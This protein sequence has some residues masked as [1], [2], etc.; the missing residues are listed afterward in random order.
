VIVALYFIAVLLC[1]R[2]A[3]ALSPRKNNARPKGTRAKITAERWLWKGLVVA[4]AGL[5]INK[6]LDL[7]TA[8]TELGR[9]LAHG[10]GFY[11]HR[12]LVQVGFVLLLAL[13]ALAVGAIF[14]LL[15][16]GSPRPTKLAVVG[17]GV[18]LLF[19]LLRAAA[20]Q[21][22]IVA[23]SGAVEF[24]AEWLLEVAGLLA[25]GLG[26]RSRLAGRP[27]PVVAR[28]IR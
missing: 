1:G 20:F 6:Q 4:L 12:A 21:S 18:L 3:S 10:L 16:W 8:L 2:V 14:A 13:A 25:I 28:Q 9:V 15:A 11:E 22:S 17:L 27:P 26:A 7:Q 24:P 5:G 23:T 19:V